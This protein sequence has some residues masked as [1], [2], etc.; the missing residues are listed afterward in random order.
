VNVTAQQVDTG[1]QG[2][3]AITLVLVIAHHGRAA[4]GQWCKRRRADR[5]NARL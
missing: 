1:H 4:T 5:L 3:R 2:Q